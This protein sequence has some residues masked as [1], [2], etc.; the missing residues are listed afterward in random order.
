LRAEIEDIEK[1]KAL[2]EIDFCQKEIYLISLRE[3]LKE[4]SEKLKEAEKEKDFEKLK[5]KAALITPTP[6]GTGPILVA[7]LFENFFELLEKE[8]VVI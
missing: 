7:K 1:E 4:I 5:D 8:K 3:K 6:G 2:E